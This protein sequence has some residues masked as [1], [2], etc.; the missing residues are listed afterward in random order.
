MACI[1]RRRKISQSYGEA[2][3][4]SCNIKPPLTNDRILIFQAAE[5]L[6]S[7]FT[8]LQRATMAT[9]AGSVWQVEGVE[10]SSVYRRRALKELNEN[11][12]QIQAH[13]ASFRRW[14]QSMPHLNCPTGMFRCFKDFGLVVNG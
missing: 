5:P 3:H 2:N 7:M 10:L 8:A 9:M 6:M 11:P 13:I 14:I 12:N 4:S 1:F